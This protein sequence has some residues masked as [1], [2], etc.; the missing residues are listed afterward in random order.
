MK[1]SGYS[2]VRLSYLLSSYRKLGIHV[3]VLDVFI[4]KSGIVDDLSNQ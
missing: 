4:I 2:T 3:L 1:N